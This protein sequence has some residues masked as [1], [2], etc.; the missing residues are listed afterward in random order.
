MQ[1]IGVTG[2]A[3]LL[4]GAYAFGHVA[5]RKVLA[6][7]RRDLRRTALD[8]ATPFAGGGP[9]GAVPDAGPPAL[10][11]RIAR[12]A[13][14]QAMARDLLWSRCGWALVLAGILLLAVASL[15]ALPAHGGGAQGPVSPDA[16][17]SQPSGSG[18]GAA[19]QARSDATMLWYGLTALFLLVGGALALLARP[20]WVKATGVASMALA[21][22][23]HG[24]TLFK[25]ER[26][27]GLDTKV[28]VGGV[29]LD[30]GL[31]I[32]RQL[33]AQSR[34]LPKYL[35]GVQGFA[36]GRATLDEA[37]FGGTGRLAEAQAALQRICAAWQEQSGRQDT[38]VLIVGGT[39][40]LA[41]AGAARTRYEANAGLAQARAASL[42]GYLEEH[43][44]SQ[45][46]AP[47][48]VLLLASGPATTPDVPSPQERRFGYPQD[49]RADVWVLSTVTPPASAASR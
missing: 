29:T 9:P 47:G 17:A 26:L 16:G 27:L 2:L 15:Q 34:F 32:R 44:G 30:I 31:E 21:A 39:D 18:T 24:T 42:R 41:L 48:R 36:L 25:F 10:E 4:A 37:G 40:R 12:A 3:L 7:G 38:M 1:W 8:A 46:S 19:G 33:Q 20:T 22:G 13:E 28:D 43:C 6:G 14:S 5:L 11:R 35:G 23:L 49:R 45:T